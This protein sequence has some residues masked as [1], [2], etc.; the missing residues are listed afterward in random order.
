M[1]MLLT[2]YPDNAPASAVA[3]ETDDAWGFVVGV[4][5][6]DSVPKATLGFGETFALA[7]WNW[8][9]NAVPPLLR[10]KCRQNHSLIFC[11]FTI[12]L[13]ELVAKPEFTQVGI[14]IGCYL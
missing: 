11:F 2:E 5:A 8:V 6:G 7:A 1:T 12:S 14:P 4:Q 3:S 10:L 9:F 13:D